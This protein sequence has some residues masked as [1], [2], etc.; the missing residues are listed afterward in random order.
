MRHGMKILCLAAAVLSGAPLSSWANTVLPF[1][2]S[3]V[4]LAGPCD[5]NQP[6]PGACFRLLSATNDYVV[7]GEPGWALDFAGQLTP[8]PD[9]GP[10]PTYLGA[11]TFRFHRGG[12]SL[13]GDWTNLFIPAPPPAGCE[14][15]FFGDPDCWPAESQSLLDYRILSG[16]GAFAGATGR[17]NGQLFVVTGFPP[18]NLENP[19][20]GSQYRE[21]GVL[22]VPE[23]G[24]LAL[25]GLGLLVAGMRR[26]S[27]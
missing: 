17:G 10:P 21:T 9:P 24:T 7:A 6:D 26:R 4:V 19:Q 1:T 25:F 5:P 13:A 27:T 8:N 14:P 16:T 20:A 23:P 18:G 15:P 3:G 12:D 2:G 22:Y 11:G